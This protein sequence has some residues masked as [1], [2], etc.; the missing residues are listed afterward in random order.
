[1]LSAQINNLESEHIHCLSRSE[2]AQHINVSVNNKIRLLLNTD[3]IAK[4]TFYK[5]WLS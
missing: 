2:K 3:N 5:I 4:Y 1:M